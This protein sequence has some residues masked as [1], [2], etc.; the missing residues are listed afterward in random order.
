M[1]GR[2]AW[3][4]IVEMVRRTATAKGRAGSSYF[5][6]EG[7]RLHE[8][9]LRAGRRVESAVVGASFSQNLAPRV[10]RLLHDLEDAGCCL[11]VVPDDVIVEL[12]DG[13]DLGAIIGLVPMP[14][15]QTEFIQKGDQTLFLMAADVKDPGNIGALMR[16]ALAAGATAFIAC[17]ISDPYHP[18]AVRTSMG[19]L[20]KLP[21]LIFATAEEA[22]EALAGRGIQT[23]GLAVEGS[24]LL[25]ELERSATGTAVIVGSEAQGFDAQVRQKLDHLVVIPMVDAVDSY[26]VNAAAAIALYELGLRRR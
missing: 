17:G 25:P 9:A 5:S 11:H 20:F 4:G 13:R 16:T 6:I 19:S 1:S 2:Q 18:K 22:L 23:V 10:Q 14:K 26:S 24:L 21:V 3:S 8:R 7:T 15:S 12:T